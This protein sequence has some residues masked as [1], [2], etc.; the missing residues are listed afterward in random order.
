MSWLGI[1]C[2]ASRVPKAGAQHESEFDKLLLEGF[3]LLSSRGHVQSDP[4]KISRRSIEG[5]FGLNAQFSED[6]FAKKR[7][8]YNPAKESVVMPDDSDAFNFTKVDANEIIS[9]VDASRP[10]RPEATF[11]AG[12]MY[13]EVSEDQPHPVN[14]TVLA[15]ASPL[16]VGHVLFVPSLEQKMPQVINAQLLLCGLNLLTMSKRSDFRILYNSLQG[17]ASV[18]HFHFHGLYLDHCSL[19]TKRLPI[20]NVNRSTVAGD[21]T[22]GKLCIELLAET[23]WYV[24]GFVLT[25]GCPPGR[26]KNMVSDTI[27][28]PL[29]DLEI[30][31]RGAGRLLEE[32]QRRNIAHNVLIAPFSTDRRPANITDLIIK[33]EL[34]APAASPEIY[35]IPRHPDKNLRPDAGFNAG[36]SELCGLLVA[37][38]EQHFNNFAEKTLADIFEDISLSGAEMDELICK[39]AWLGA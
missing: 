24:R 12:L 10:K 35:I 20:E 4:S 13:D 22:E 26:S 16:A 33:G 34:A 36:I 29:P 7:Q 6:H 39:F 18:N 15:S 37:H 25:A 27:Q 5:S 30:L 28:H 9:S 31:A 1:N 14:V 3:G 17:C 11:F 38:D 2:C 8:K 21:R 19:S 32:L 23:Q